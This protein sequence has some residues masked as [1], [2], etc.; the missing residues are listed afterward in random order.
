MPPVYIYQAQMVHGG[1]PV[2]KA[3]FCGELCWPKPLSYTRSFVSNSSVLII[4]NCVGSENP[5]CEVNVPCRVEH[6]CDICIPVKSEIIRDVTTLSRKCLSLYRKVS[7]SYLCGYWCMFAVV[8]CCAHC[9]DSVCSWCM[10]AVVCLQF[11][12][13][14]QCFKNSEKEN[15]VSYGCILCANFHSGIHWHAATQKRLIG[16]FK[17][18]DSSKLFAI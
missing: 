16:D 1:A 5:C 14:S 18:V 3:K 13:M 2:G 8:C 9:F 12:K 6:Y 15:P 11:K 7:S 17:T 4:A 10:F